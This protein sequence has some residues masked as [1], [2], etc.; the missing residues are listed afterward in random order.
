M[1]ETYESKVVGLKIQPQNSSPRILTLDRSA[2]FQL[3]TAAVIDDLL[4]MKL[5]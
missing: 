4:A 2:T 1:R 5:V 3:S